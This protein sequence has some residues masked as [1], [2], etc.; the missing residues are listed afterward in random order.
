ML[1]AMPPNAPESGVR[2]CSRF[3]EVDPDAPATT[4]KEM[5]AQF[6]VVCAKPLSCDE[7]VAQFELAPNPTELHSEPQEEKL[8]TRVDA[9]WLG[10]I[11]GPQIPK[12]KH[13]NPVRMAQDEARERAIK[14]ASEIGYKFGSTISGIESALDTLHSKCSRLEEDLRDNPDVLAD[15]QKKIA[16]TLNDITLPPQYA[17]PELQGLAV[18]A[19]SRGFEDG[20]GDKKLQFMALNATATVSKKAVCTGYPRGV[21]FSI[22]R[23]FTSLSRCA[24]HL[25]H[26][27]PLRT[28][29]TRCW[30]NR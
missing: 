11:G 21:R 7:V 3:F 15:W 20:F 26:R 22:R 25:A 28:T 16:Q 12:P 6:G 4:V 8:A 14:Q 23:S 10:Q 1:R 27:R 2:A 19:F 5:P 30:W 29:R 18:G 24:T 13:P 9:R 17:D